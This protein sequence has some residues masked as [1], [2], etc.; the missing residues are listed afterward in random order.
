[1]SR[2]DQSQSQTFCIRV[3]TAR[4]SKFFE[5]E[6][7][8]RIVKV[9]GIVEG[10]KS[11]LET[12]QEKIKQLD[13]KE[14]NILKAQVEKRVSVFEKRKSALADEI[15]NATSRRQKQIKEEKIE[16]LNETIKRIEC[17]SKSTKF[18]KQMKPKLK[19]KVEQLQESRKLTNK[20]IKDLTK[21]IKERQKQIIEATNARDTLKYNIG[22]FVEDML[23][24]KRAPVRTKL[25]E[26]KNFTDIYITGGR[27]KTDGAN[28]QFQRACKLLER[29][30]VD[31]GLPRSPP[32]PESFVTISVNGV[33]G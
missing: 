6:V 2:R 10:L 14:A 22:R 3:N 12:E 30:G 11:E 29:W 21:D 8:D 4:D 23:T 32:N 33:A 19:Y 1:M 25:I 28:K 13:E 27:S 5:D 7:D 26:S 24:Q 18:F 9:P 16:G 31:Y 20:R 17:A 15:E